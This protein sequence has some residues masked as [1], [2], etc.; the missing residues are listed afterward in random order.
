MR[1]WGFCPVAMD[2]AWSPSGL[3]GGR[4]SVGL[5]WR[6]LTHPSLFLFSPP[7]NSALLETPENESSKLHCGKIKLRPVYIEVGPGSRNLR[8][9]TL[10]RMDLTVARKLARHLDWIGW[11]VFLGW[12]ETDDKVSRGDGTML[13]QAPLL[14]FHALNFH[15]MCVLLGSEI[16]FSTKKIAP[17]WG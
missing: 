3:R 7:E 6:A 8:S 14:Y 16:M 15:T 1:N 4:S 12:N 13:H 9:K 10:L 5:W 17:F 2:F 11:N